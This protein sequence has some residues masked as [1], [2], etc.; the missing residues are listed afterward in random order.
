MVDTL[1]LIEE[2]NAI[3]EQYEKTGMTVKLAIGCENDE[4]IFFTEDGKGNGV[5]IFKISILS[6]VTAIKSYEREK[7]IIETLWSD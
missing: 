7:Q 3:K 1:E 6:L 2:L 4:F 5:A